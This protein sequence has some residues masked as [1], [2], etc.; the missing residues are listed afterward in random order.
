M[1]RTSWGTTIDGAPKTRPIGLG[2]TAL[3]DGLRTTREEA[4]VH[5]AGV[6]ACLHELTRRHAECCMAQSRD[7]DEKNG[8]IAA[9][10]QALAEKAAREALAEAANKCDVAEA[11]V[12]AES[13]RADV[14]EAALAAEKLARQQDAQRLEARVLF[15]LDVDLDGSGSIDYYELYQQLRAGRKNFS[16]PPPRARKR[17]C[18]R[19]G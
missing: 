9:R 14:A 17:V 1:V 2:A 7:T 15:G 13:A 6:Q 5:L 4:S 12:A 11:R 3:R 10:E 19:T 8:A 16:K 18:A